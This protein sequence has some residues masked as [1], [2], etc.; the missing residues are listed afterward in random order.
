[1]I[2]RD[3]YEALAQVVADRDLRGKLGADYAGYEVNFHPNAGLIAKILLARSSSALLPELQ[4]LLPENVMVGGQPVRVF[5]VSIAD[6][7]VK[8]DL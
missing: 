3:A 1:M 8:A 2:L 4:Q 7:S 6:V 5:A